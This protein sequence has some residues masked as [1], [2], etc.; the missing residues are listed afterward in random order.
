MTKKSKKPINPKPNKIALVAIAVFCITIF[1]GGY[2][3]IKSMMPKTFK[4]DSEMYGTSEAIDIDKEAYEKLIQE[5]KS[6]VVMV[7]KPEC[8]TTA[9]MRK[10]MSEFPEDMQFKYY[11][12]MWSQAR[13]S[14]LHDYVKFVPSVAIIHNGEVVDFLDADSDED[15]PKYNEAQALQDWI[16]SYIVFENSTSE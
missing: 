13:E 2:F 1:F 4:L 9:D 7:D 10:R 5:K 6:F 8:Y 11:R 15:T 16:K 12:I 14:S 3:L